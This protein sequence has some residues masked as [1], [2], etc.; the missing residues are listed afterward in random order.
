MRAGP[1]RAGLARSGIGKRAGPV[2]QEIW[3]LGNFAAATIFPRK[4]GR[5][6]SAQ[7]QSFLGIQLRLGNRAAIAIA[8]TQVTKRVGRN[9]ME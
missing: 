5:G 8:G 4:F 2:S 9:A 1:C 7:R 3:P 6:V